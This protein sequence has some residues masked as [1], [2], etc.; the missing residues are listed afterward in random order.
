MIMP[1]NNCLLKQYLLSAYN[2]PGPM[3]SK[4]K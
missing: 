4:E 2:F 1:A 3:L